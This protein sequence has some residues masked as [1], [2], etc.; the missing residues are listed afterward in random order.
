MPTVGPEVATTLAW[1]L[2][3]L[4]ILAGLAGTLLP[5]LPGAPLV[6]AGLLTA[7]WADGFQRVGGAVLIVLAGLTALSFLV[8]LIAAS[9]GAK[10]AGASR[11]ALIGAAIGTVVGLFFGIAGIVIGPFIGAVAGEFLSRGSAA[12]AGRV[13]AWTWVGFIF[14]TLVKLVLAFTMVGI[15][16]I[17][18][19]ID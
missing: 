17:A 16:L 4:L 15:F 11:S 12:G 10:R 5:A 19:M 3:A 14:G 13:G 6:F 18:Y 7:A 1:V 8:D 2:A 9:L